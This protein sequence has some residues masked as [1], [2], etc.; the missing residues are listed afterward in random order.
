MWEGHWKRKCTSSSSKLH[1]RKGQCLSSFVVWLYLPYNTITDKSTT[2]EKF[3]TGGKINR[4]LIYRSKKGLWYR[5][6][7]DLICKLKRFDLEENSLAWLTSYLTNRTQAV[8]VEDELSSPMPVLSGV[9]QGCTVHLLYKRPTV[10]YPILQHHD[11]GGRHS[12]LS[13]FHIHLGHWT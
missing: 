8:C 6:R 2:A 12:D 11:V 5:P 1:P 9:P 4:G 10:L 13:V 3:K 7:D